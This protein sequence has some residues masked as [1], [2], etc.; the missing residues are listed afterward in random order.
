M[1]ARLAAA[2]MARAP[3]AS[4]ARLPCE[5]ATIRLLGAAGRSVERLAGAEAV[6]DW[7]W[8]GGETGATLRL[9][10]TAGEASV[11]AEGGERVVAAAANERQVAVALGGGDVVY[12]ELDASGALAALAAA[13]GRAPSSGAAGPPGGAPQRRR[14]AS[15]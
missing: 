5:V 7:Q 6:T 2:A 1:R 4:P 9:E 11:T 13:A 14:T 10:G 12:F 15:S 8:W 3:A